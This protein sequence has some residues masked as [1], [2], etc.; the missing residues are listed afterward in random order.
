VRVA[1]VDDIPPALRDEL[2]TYLLASSFERARV[3]G[4]DAD[5]RDGRAAD[6]P[7]G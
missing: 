3:I 2:V 1:S 4:D 5:P 7:R 6:G